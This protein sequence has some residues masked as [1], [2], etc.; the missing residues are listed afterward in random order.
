MN[1]SDSIIKIGNTE[2]TL[3]IGNSSFIIP[4]NKRE[5]IKDL[6]IYA[7]NYIHNNVV[8]E[9]E[10]QYT[11]ETWVHFTP[12]TDE[13]ILNAVDEGKI[14]IRL[15]LL[16]HYPKGAGWGTNIWIDADQFEYP[17]LGNNAKDPKK[18]VRRG[19]FG[20]HAASNGNVSYRNLTKKELMQGYLDDAIYHYIIDGYLTGKPEDDWMRNHVQYAIEMFVPALHISQMNPYDLEYLAIR[21]N[22][23][24]L[25]IE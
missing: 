12:I 9:F 22:F 13:K 10:E 18:V 21:T 11:D 19:A 17:E 25:E 20:S 6:S 15:Q 23:S 16:V 5:T 7:A 2:F 3:K 1:W 8:M 4:I 14:Q 24:T